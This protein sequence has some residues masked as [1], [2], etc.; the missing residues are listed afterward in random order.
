M[1]VKTSPARTSAMENTYAYAE[2]KLISTEKIA[3]PEGYRI[4]RIYLGSY[5]NCF[6]KKIWGSPFQA[7]EGV[8]FAE[9]VKVDLRSLQLLKW[10]CC[11]KELE[12]LLLEG[13]E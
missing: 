2:Y 11:P 5:F 6:G 13:L 4:K 12:A 10:G 3:T 9:G 7:R 8:T 1:A